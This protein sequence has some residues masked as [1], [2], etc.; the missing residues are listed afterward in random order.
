MVRG[1]FGMSR[2]RE[3]PGPSDAEAGIWRGR[4]I[5]RRFVSSDGL[6][7]LVGRSAADNDVLTLRLAAPRDFWLH[8]AGSSGSHVVVR[9]PDGLERMPRA[10]AQLAAALAAGH[11]RARAGGSVAVHVARCADVRKPR[12][13]AAGQV[14]LARF[15]TVHATPLQETPEAAEAPGPSRPRQQRD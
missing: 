7:V 9:N 1:G 11:S 2:E 13:F 8:V 12:G 4:S 3:S 10:T 15:S 14:Q 6:T 5:A